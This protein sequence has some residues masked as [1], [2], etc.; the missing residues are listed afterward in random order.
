MLIDLAFLIP[1]LSLFHSFIHYRKNVPL[2]DFV[3]V[4]SS[5]IIEAH[6]I[7]VNN[8]LE[9]ENLDKNRGSLVVNDLQFY[10]KD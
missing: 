3:L 2:K 6:D 5:L 4:G 10:K 1:T 9:K 7:L 8:F